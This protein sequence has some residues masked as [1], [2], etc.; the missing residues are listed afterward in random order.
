M[1]KIRQMEADRY[2]SDERIRQLEAAL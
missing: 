2:K 1:S